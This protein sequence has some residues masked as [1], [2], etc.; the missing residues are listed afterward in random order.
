[1]PSQRP[2][3]KGFV[4]KTDLLLSLFY[5]WE[6]MVLVRIYTRSANAPKVASVHRLSSG[7]TPVSAIDPPVPY[8]MLLSLSTVGE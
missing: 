6:Y 1:M 5:T 3:N 2:G 8:S 4:G 7:D